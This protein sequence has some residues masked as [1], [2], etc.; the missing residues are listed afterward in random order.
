[1][2]DA[3]EQEGAEMTDR[4]SC[5]VPF[6]RRTFKN[7][8]GCTEVIC[9]KHWRLAAPH[10]RRRKTKLFRLYRKRFGDTPFWEYPAGSPK[11]LEAVKIDRLCDRAWKIC[12]KQAI[13]RAAGI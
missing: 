7:D 2:A 13:E 12:K 9:G 10:L 6:C 3:Q 4:I 11:R 1:M 8:E 5:C